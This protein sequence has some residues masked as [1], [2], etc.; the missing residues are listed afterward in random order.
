VNDRFSHDVGDTVLRRVADLL[1][2]NLREEDVVMRYGG[3]EFVLL[4]PETRKSEAVVACEKLRHA[5][6]ACEFGTVE[7]ALAVTMSF[8]VA[9]C[10]EAP[11]VGGILRVAD[12]RLYQAKSLGRNRVESG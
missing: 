6:E 11:D 8:G 1:Q 9:D 3:E 5:I 7:G 12:E 4:L 2:T 10:S